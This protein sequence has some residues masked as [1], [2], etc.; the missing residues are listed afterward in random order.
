MVPLLKY[1][2]LRLGLFVASLAVLALLGARGVLLLV[3]AA[4]ISVALSYLLLRGPRQ[5]FAVALEERTR[6]RLEAHAER[7]LG[8]LA[9]DEAAEDAAA[10]AL[11]DQAKSGD[12][13][14]SA[15]QPQ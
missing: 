6:Q 2:V 11:R 13:A 4:G 15:D 3:L 7:P 8:G 5:E 9:A 14:R 10:D 1:S 12:Q